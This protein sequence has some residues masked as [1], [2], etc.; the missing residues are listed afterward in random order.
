M[1]RY[2]GLTDTELIA[3]LRRYGIPP[4]PVV[5]ST[6]KLYERKICE[7]ESQRTKLS[8]PGGYSDPGT[9]ETYIRES[10]SYPQQEERR[11]YGADDMDEESSSSSSS[12][13]LYGA[14]PGPLGEATARQPIGEATSYTPSRSEETESRDGV[15]YQRVCR[16]RPA[17]PPMRVEPRRAI[18]PL[19]RGGP[20]GAG[21]GGFRRFL[22]LWLQLLLFGAL[23]AF[24]G[25]VYWALQGGADDNPFVLPP[26]E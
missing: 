13:W 19:P 15:S 1:E 9:T 24:L 12:S 16:A 8:P 21:E 17:P 23:A 26:E 18:H 7:Y 2:R 22:P 6:R 11:R 3:M 10:Y 25:Y 14:A 5:G 4:G 20:G